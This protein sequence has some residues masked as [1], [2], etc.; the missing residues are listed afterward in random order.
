M[1]QG[2][3]WKRPA[4]CPV[5]GGQLPSEQY[6]VFVSVMNHE[7]L[8]PLGS[9]GSLKAGTALPCSLPVLDKRQAPLKYPWSEW[10]VAKVAHACPSLCD[11]MD[12]TVH[13]ILQARIL[14]W[15][16]FSF[17]GGSSQPRDRTS[18][19][20]LQVDSLPAEPQGGE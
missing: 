9:T 6:N 18:S 10:V 16:A 7:A 19:P 15:V 14:E 17:S 12:Y 8:S 1:R 20:A 2:L 4:C 3:T 5:V 13:G 11:P